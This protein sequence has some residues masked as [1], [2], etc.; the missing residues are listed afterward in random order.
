MIGVGFGLQQGG[1]GRLGRP[2]YLGLPN[3]Q[4]ILH[5]DGVSGAA[6]FVDSSPKKRAP[7]L[8]SLLHSS[9]QKVFGP[10]S[11]VSTGSGNALSYA[12]SADFTLGTSNW[13]LGAFVRFDAAGTQQFVCGQCDSAGNNTSLSVSLRRTSGNRMRGLC[14]SGSSVIGDVTGTVAISATTW[15]WVT[16]GREGSTFRL[17]VDGVADGTASSASSINDSSN[18]FTWGGLGEITTGGLAG[19]LDDC[20]FEVGVYRGNMARPAFAFPDL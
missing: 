7:T 11:I 6:G 3:M 2:R 17:Y 4:F 8:V 14:A 1:F 9:A 16:Y 19:Y 10:T 15:Y 13:W 5:G 18:R 20:V 12:D